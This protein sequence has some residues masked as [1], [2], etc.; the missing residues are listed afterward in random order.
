MRIE[1]RTQFFSLS[2]FVLVA[3]CNGTRPSD[4]GSPAGELLPCP[5]KPNCVVSSSKSDQDHQIDPFPLQSSGPIAIDQLEKII[6][7]MPRT[8]IVAK[9]DNYIWVEF[10]SLIFR[11]VDDVEFY[12]PES[13][14]KILVRSASRLGHSDMGAN[15]K[16]VETL[17]EKYLSQISP[18]K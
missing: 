10:E 13:Q 2:L 18:K 3:A 15:R 4:L 7:E 9:K 1:A 5:S 6:S 11:F 12:V 8:S 17:R 14:D 16:R